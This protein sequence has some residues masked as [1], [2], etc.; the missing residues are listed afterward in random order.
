MDR[1]LLEAIRKW[2]EQYL[3]WLT[4]HP[5][6]KDEMNA[7]NNHG[8]CWVMQAAAFAKFTGNTTLIQFC[9]DRYKQVL[10]PNQ[11]AADGSFPQELRRTK[12]Y[13]YSIFNLD[14]MTTICQLLSTPQDNLWTFATPD[15]RNIRKGIEYL[16]PFIVNKTKWPKPPDVMYWENWPVAQPFLL[17][18]ATVYENKNWLN[19]WKSLDHAPKVEEVIRNLPVRNPVIWLN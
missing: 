3:Q 1:Q 18:G 14:A 9:K 15:G 19:T 2:F 10:L 16:Y 7:A 6:G 17:F 12:S 13:G 5:Y 4:T 8:T 11:M